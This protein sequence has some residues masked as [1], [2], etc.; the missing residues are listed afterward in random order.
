MLRISQLRL[1]IEESLDL[2]PKK[3][4]QKLHIQE[5]DLISYHIFKESIDARKKDHIFFNYIVD[6]KVKGEDRILKKKF[7]DVTKTPDYRYHL[8]EKGVVGMKHRPIIVGFG[9]A[10]M[11]SALLLAQMGYEPIIFERGS[12]IEQRVE[13]VERFWKEGILDT[14]NNVQ[15]GEGGAGTFSDGKLTTRVKDPRVHKILEEF[16]RFG[17]PEEILYQAY[18]HIGTDLLRGIVRAIR[19]E[20][21]ALGGEIHFSSC[22]EEL[23]IE[24]GEIQGVKVKGHTYES[25]HVILAIGHS[26]RDTYH[27]LKEKGVYMKAKAFAVGAR[28]EHPQSLINRAQYKGFADHPRLGAAEYRLTHMASN[29][30]GVYTF[31]MCPGGTV[32]PSTSCKG[33]VVVNGMSEHARDKENANSALLV[34]IRTSDFDDDPMKGI[35]FQ[36]AIE[37]KAFIAGGSTYQAPAQLVKDF[38]RHTPSKEIKRVKP[39]YALGVTLCNL[40]EVLPKEVCEAMAEGIQSFDHKLRGFAMDDA[41]LTGVETRSSSPIRLERSQEE[42]TSISVKGLYPCGEGAGYA[43]GIVSSA[44]DGLRCAEKIITYYHYEGNA[45]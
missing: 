41:V 17:A 23:L 2:I 15:F 1:D 37:Q 4:M 28:I 16:V 20:I 36:E 39:S 42:H 31:C 18:P 7:K 8:P 30:R 22:V 21:I 40:H 13:A 33:G 29:G 9:P 26:A 27:M 35:A 38:L 12:D 11:F 32:V 14:E 6:C 19:E 5:Q 45:D 25:E 10:G 34:Q 24:H 3:I 44:I 43:G